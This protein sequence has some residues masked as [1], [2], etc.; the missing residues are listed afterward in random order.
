VGEERTLREWKLGQFWT[1]TF[2]IPV[3]MRYLEKPSHVTAPFW[4]NAESRKVH[5]STIKKQDFEKGKKNLKKKRS[6]LNAV[7]PAASC[8]AAVSRG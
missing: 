3:R 1:K 6:D 4:Q 2:I 8:E 5:S 7:K